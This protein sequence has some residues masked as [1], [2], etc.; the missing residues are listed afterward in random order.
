MWNTFDRVP[1]PMLSMDDIY[2]LLKRRYGNSVRDFDVERRRI[3]DILNA[4]E[5]PVAKSSNRPC[6]Y[7]VVEKKN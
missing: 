3:S 4:T 5:N 6:L 1:E 2:A 7:G